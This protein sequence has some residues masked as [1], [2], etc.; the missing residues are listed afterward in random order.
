MAD[1]QID[2]TLDR[3]DI[4]EKRDGTARRCELISEVL[5]LGISLVNTW[6]RFKEI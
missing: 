4:K 1:V 3:P 2:L 6:K 5:P